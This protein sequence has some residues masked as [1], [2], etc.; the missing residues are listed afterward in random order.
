MRDSRT[1]P[2]EVS[3]VVPIYNELENLPDLVERIHGAMATQPL[4]FE[5]IA[6]DDGSSDGSAARLRE[7][8][9]GRPWLFREIEHF[10]K[11]GE[12]LPAPKVCEIHD[13]LLA[14]LDDLYD[15]YGVETG[16]RVARKHISWYTRGLAGSAAF[17]HAMNQ[18]PDVAGQRQAVNDFFFGLAEKH[19]HLDELQENDND[20][21]GSA[22]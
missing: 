8:A 14:H 11:T 16:V 22:S 18:L 4:S 20:R 3:I 2:P 15:F 13:I 17:R 1:T 19:E 12:R 9:Q 5:L 21:E 6:V 10:L 7:L